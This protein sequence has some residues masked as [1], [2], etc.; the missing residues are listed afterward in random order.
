MPAGD[1]PFIVD[2][3]CGDN[4]VPGTFG[5][6]FRPF[7]GIVDLVA[8][9][10]MITPDLLPRP[11]D[12]VIARHVLEHFP[13]RDTQHIL[14]RWVELLKPGGVIHI[15]VPRM[16]FIARH[17]FDRPGDIDHQRWLLDMAYGG[18]D[19]PGNF[20]QTLYS[21]ELLRHEMRQAGL[22]D[23]TIQDAVQVAVGEG[24]RPANWTPPEVGPTVV[25]HFPV[26]GR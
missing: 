13:V 4:K 15:E 7:P 12:A 17:W 8:D 23:I 14:I 3:G 26:T 2:L 16:D 9:V 19:Y 5:V 20:H 6:D 22:V 11:A 25:K 21:L 18:Q 1:E 24:R 10:S